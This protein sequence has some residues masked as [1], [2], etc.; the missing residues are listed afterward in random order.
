MKEIKITAKFQG[1]QMKQVGFINMSVRKFISQET[2][3][4]NGK[5]VPKWEIL[6]DPDNSA[7]K[8]LEEDKIYFSNE[9]YSYE[10]SFVD[11]EDLLISTRD[12]DKRI[13]VFLS[14]KVINSEQSVNIKDNSYSAKI[15]ELKNQTNLMEEEINQ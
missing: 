11:D 8:K 4:E 9:H 2:E 14:D 6:I 12:E 7:I 15:E 5:E 1:S 13:R 10:I 3:K